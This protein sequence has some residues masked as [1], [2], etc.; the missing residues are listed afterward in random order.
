MK[1]LNK[2]YTILKSNHITAYNYM[3]SKQIGVCVNFIEIAGTGHLDANN[4]TNVVVVAISVMKDKKRKIALNSVMFSKFMTR[5]ENTL[6]TFREHHDYHGT[7]YFTSLYGEV[8]DKWYTLLNCHRVFLIPKHHLNEAVEEMFSGDNI[9][10]FNQ[11]G[12][13]DN[14]VITKTLSHCVHSQYYKE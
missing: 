9:D 2:I 4:G 1:V 12:I 3:P 10:A 13:E 7:M 11:Y 5:I 14:F 6:S 8:G